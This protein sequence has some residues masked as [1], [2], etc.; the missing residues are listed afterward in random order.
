MDNGRFEDERANTGA[1][2]LE[3]AARP[4]VPNGLDPRSERDSTTADLDR[5][6]MEIAVRV[7]SVW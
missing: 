3:Q 2:N 7:R 6:A 5:A 4:A 1:A